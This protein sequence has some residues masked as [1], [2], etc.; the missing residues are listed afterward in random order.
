ME[1]S[2][3]KDR[4][5]TEPAPVPELPEIT[6]SLEAICRLLQKHTGHDF[7]KYKK[8]TLLRRIGRRLQGLHVTV[9]ADYIQLLELSAA[10]AEALVKD[11]LIGVTQFFRDPE[12]F[13]MLARQVLPRITSA[14]GEQA[15]LRIWVPGSASGEE[16]YTIAMLVREHLEQSGQKLVVQLFATDIDAGILAQA[17]QGRYS[18]S[19]SESVSAERL[20][21]FFTR[22]GEGY[23]ASK[24][25]REMC[26]FS[27]HSLIR[28]PPFSQLD[29][30]SCRNVL[31]YL[32]ADVQKRLVPLFHYALR[33][34][35]P[36]KAS[37]RVRSCSRASTR[38]AASSVAKTP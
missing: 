7:S 10:E 25:L 20:E 26:L 24:E 12:T 22:E 33:P 5:S 34:G 3:G 29:L 31:I 8:A 32:N 13:D 16:A 37:P 17:R 15:P 36:P 4:G 27:Q 30:I 6:A 19:I 35:V 21:R 18:S 38:R 9:V 23:Q 28:D 14:K 2:V 11:I 1:P